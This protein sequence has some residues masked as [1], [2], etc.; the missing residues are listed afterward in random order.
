MNS[1][2]QGKIPPYLG[3][4]P[5]DRYAKSC[6]AIDVCGLTPVGDGKF[7]AS[8][9][10][11]HWD[12]APSA[13]HVTAIVKELAATR[14][15]MIDG[16]QG[17]AAKGNRLRVSERLTGA[18]G[19]TPDVRP[20]LKRPFGGF[21]WSSLDLF[22]ALA[23]AGTPISPPGFSGGVSEVY[24]GHLWKI[25]AG[26]GLPKKGTV[27]GRVRRKRILEILGV[28]GLPDLPTHD[29]NDACVAAVVAAAAESAVPGV[30]VKGMGTPLISVPEGSLREGLIVVLEAKAGTRDLISRVLQ[31]P[32]S[33]Q[34]LLGEHQ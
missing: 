10:F 18:P 21:I 31:R 2:H 22:A 32:P 33:T 8:F 28:S 27:E 4:D 30:T 12:P 1:T 13:L 7:T 34:R 17:L 24:P 3:I 26:P 29:E 23:Q 19:K 15:A 6:R 5:T 25:L 14:A 20:E 16:P 11:W 9:W